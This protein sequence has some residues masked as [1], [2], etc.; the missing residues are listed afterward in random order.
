MSRKVNWGVIGSGG[1]ARRRT[2]PEGITRAD[3]AKRTAVYDANAEV[4]E[5]V[6]MQF[7]T[8]AAGSLEEF[9]SSGID[10]VYVATPA[11]LHYEHVLSCTR[12]GKHVL[13]EKPLGMTL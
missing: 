12:A 7:D 5:E 8:T 13:C 4:N 9:L 1:I 3:D 6:A 10:A 11:Y 2:I